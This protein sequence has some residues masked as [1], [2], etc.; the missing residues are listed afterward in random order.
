MSVRCRSSWFAAL[1]AIPVS[2]ALVAC[3]SQGAPTAAPS[4]SRTSASKAEAPKATG[5]PASEQPEPAG[6]G[7]EKLKG[8]DLLERV[9]E[10]SSNAESLRIKGTVKDGKSA[11][12]F[13]LTVTGKGDASGTIGVDD[14]KFEIIRIGKTVYL[15]GNEAFYGEA[16]KETLKELTSN[17]VKATTDDKDFAAFIDL[18]KLSTIFEGFLPDGPTLLVKGER[19][20]VNDRPALRLGDL[21]GS[22]WVATEGEPY[23]LRLDAGK[24]GG[25]DFL[26]Y[27][28]PFAPKAPDKDEVLETE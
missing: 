1:V 23:I 9:V 17:Y 6:N 13:N 5:S 26:D 12:T 15:K 8:K 10:A 28:K 20:V 16:D 4:P 25:L 18:T 7:I 2:F 24:Q 14:V 19:K 22:I 3:G 21:S 11:V 27:D